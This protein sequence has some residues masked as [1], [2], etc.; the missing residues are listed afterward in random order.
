MTE[1]RSDITEEE[2]ELF[3]KYLGDSYEIISSLDGKCFVLSGFGTFLYN[4]CF[5]KTDDP[6]FMAQKYEEFFPVLAI[7]Y[8]H[9]YL[10]VD[11]A[12][13]WFKGRKDINGNY[14]LECSADTFADLAESL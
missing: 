2:K 8:F 3:D 11:E 13:E 5:E 9:D 7:K 12:G 4:E 6:F 10:M 14:E 1:L